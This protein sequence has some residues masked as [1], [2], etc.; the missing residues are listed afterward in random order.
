M[1]N[2]HVLVAAGSLLLASSVGEPAFAQK[3]GGILRMSHLTARRACQCTRK[4]RP[5]PTGR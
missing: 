1:K 5:P 2:V 3:Q 4:R